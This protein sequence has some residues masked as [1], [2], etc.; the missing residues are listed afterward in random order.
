MPTGTTSFL[1]ARDTSLLITWP[2]PIP[3]PLT[4]LSF[5]LLATLPSYSLACT[6]SLPTHITS[7][8][9]CSKSI[10]VRVLAN[11][12][13][14][15][16]HSL[17]FTLP[18]FCLLATLL[19]LFPCLNHFFAC[20]NCIICLLAPLTHSLCF[21]HVG[22]TH[23]SRIDLNKYIPLSAWIVFKKVYK[24]QG[25]GCRMAQAAFWGCRKPQAEHAGNRSMRRLVA[26]DWWCRKPQAENA[27]SRRLGMPEATG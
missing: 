2:V 7:F 13:Q 19:C 3:S 6:T 24:S 18:P 12:T 14:L 26:T 27:G 25:W 21:L 15:L 8:F 20:P 17:V 9:N 16:I 23:F 5:C 22:W 10:L 4:L 1:P 11:F